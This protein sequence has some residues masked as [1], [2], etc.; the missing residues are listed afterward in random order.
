MNKDILR[1]QKLNRLIGDLVSALPGD[2][3]MPDVRAKLNEIDAEFDQ[4][5]KEYQTEGENKCES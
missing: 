3:F 2:A 1:L 4:W 5:L